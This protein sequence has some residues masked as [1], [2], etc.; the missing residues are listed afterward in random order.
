EGRAARMTTDLAFIL[1]ALL[2]M[3]PFSF[4]PFSNT[5]PALALLLYAIG[6]IQRDGGAILLGHAANIGTMVYFAVLVGGGGAAAHGIFQKL[7]GCP[8]AAAPRRAPTGD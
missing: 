7:T 2:L 8:H 5:L 4:V 6:M 3:A 1:A